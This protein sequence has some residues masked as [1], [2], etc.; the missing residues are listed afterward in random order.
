[1]K[2]II[3]L[4]VFNNISSHII[5]R[6][7]N[8]RETWE[9]ASD[10]EDSLT[11]DFCRS[12]SVS[13]TSPI[14]IRGRGSWRWRVSYKK[15]RGRGNG[16]FEK[17]CG[18]DGIFQIEVE[19]KNTGK[20]QRKG[21]LFQAKKNKIGRTTDLKKQVIKMET[22]APGSS[23]IF[24]YSSDHF[25]AMSSKDFIKY[26][27]T[28][29]PQSPNLDNIGNF[30][31]VDFLECRVGKRGLYYDG[32]RKILIVPRNGKQPRLVRVD[33]PHRISIDVESI[34]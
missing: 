1:M 29:V 7:T 14:L 31:G 28:S 20:V 12:L 27:R 22:L 8:F 30:L 23:S 5:S 9:S 2:S 18:A 25:G 26:Y 32:L 11:G 17:I 24:A 33:V 13:W 4:K 10:E 15:F 21:L 3:P 34:E 19:N 6:S 16:A